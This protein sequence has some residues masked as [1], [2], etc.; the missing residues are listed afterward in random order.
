M[1]NEKT[2]LFIPNKELNICHMSTSFMGLTLYSIRSLKIKGLKYPK[3]FYV[4]TQ[5]TESYLLIT[6]KLALQFKQTKFCSLMDIKLELHIM[7]LYKMYLSCSMKRFVKV[8][9]AKNV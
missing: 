8:L 6:E 2:A 5:I 4:S 1:L 9:A 3:Q 7:D